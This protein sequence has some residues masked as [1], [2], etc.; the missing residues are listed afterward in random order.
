MTGLFIQCCYS[1]ISLVMFVQSGLLLLDFDE[2]CGMPVPIHAVEIHH[3]L[4]LVQN[5]CCADS[6]EYKACT[7]FIV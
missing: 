3:S 5:G 1:E 6:P 2:K 4:S 7:D